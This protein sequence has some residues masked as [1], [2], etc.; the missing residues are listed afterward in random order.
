MT[1]KALQIIGEHKS[2]RPIA[3]VILALSAGLDPDPQD[4]AVVIQSL[5][6]AMYTP[7]GRRLLGMKPRARG[8]SARYDAWH[9]LHASLA[10]GVALHDSPAGDVARRFSQGTLT[11]AQARDKLAEQIGDGNYKTFDRLLT[12]LCVA[13][14]YPLPD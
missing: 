10:E 13:L 5:F 6:R 12:D 7:E 8:H 2:E 3:R 1:A 14:T 9:Y 11:R 4:A